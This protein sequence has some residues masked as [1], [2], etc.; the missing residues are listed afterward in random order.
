MI[1]VKH[2]GSFKNIEN[3]LRR[4]REL[5]IHDILSAY[6]SRGVDYLKQATPKRTGKTS[7]SWMYTIENKKGE[8]TITWHNTNTTDSGIPVVILL[9]Y[10]HAT[11]S[12]VY[13]KG[14]DFITPS[15]APLF[16]KMADEIWREVTK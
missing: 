12:G 11:K 13:V 15:I 10:G 1:E 4:N 3:F 5:N 9:Y 16:D 6:G 2:S 7:E 14:S 8:Y